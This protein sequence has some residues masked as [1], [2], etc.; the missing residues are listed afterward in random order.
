[1]IRPEPMA[2]AYVPAQLAALQIYCRS[3]SVAVHAS[4][5]TTFAISRPFDPTA[6]DRRSAGPIDFCRPDADL[7]GRIGC[8]LLDR[9][10]SRRFNPTLTGTSPTRSAAI[11]VASDER[12]RR[13]SLPNTRHTLPVKNRR[14][15]GIATAVKYASA[16]TFG[17]Q[18]PIE[19]DGRPIANVPG[20]TTYPFFSYFALLHIMLCARGMRRLPQDRESFAARRRLAVGAFPCRV[21]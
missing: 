20:Q 18:A 4:P 1:M 8:R 7:S 11:L 15:V 16:S 10:H 5:W 12:R 21:V 14:P 3:V 6:G 13:R 2:R 17:T 19:L 9:L